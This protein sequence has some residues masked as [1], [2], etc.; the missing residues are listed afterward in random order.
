MKIQVKTRVRRGIRIWRS[1]SHLI[2]APTGGDGTRR[3]LSRL[4]CTFDRVLIRFSLRAGKRADGPIGPRRRLDL[5]VHER[6]NSA[7]LH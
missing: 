4:D 5:E 1:E 6:R 2:T 7:R 3:E